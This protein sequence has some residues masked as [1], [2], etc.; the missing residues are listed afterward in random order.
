MSMQTAELLAITPTLTIRE[1][2]EWDAVT[3]ADYVAEIADERPNNTAIRRAMFPMSADG[4]REL[5][6]RY[7]EDGGS[8]FLVAEHEGEIAGM[9]RMTR[10]D[11]PYRRHVVTLSINLRRDMRGMGLGRRMMQEA[12][13]WAQTQPDIQRIELEAL[14]RNRA[15]LRV[16]ERL[17][18]HV[19][20]IHRKM[21]QLTDEDGAPFVDAVVMTYPLDDETP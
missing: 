8:L 7:R 6:R 16:Y 11:A 18:F 10:G 13:A 4:I 1:V 17:G 12:L 3:L 5:L 19:E 21:Y 20:G 2:N 14:T 15:A 9:I